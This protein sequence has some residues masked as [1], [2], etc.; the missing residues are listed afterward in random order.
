MIVNKVRQRVME[1]CK[2]KENLLTSAFFE[3]HLCVVARYG[4]LLAEAMNADSEMVEV[5]SYLHDLSAV[6]DFTTL[7]KHARE[8]SIQ[9]EA[10]LT[11]Y[12]YPG[13]KI[14]TIKNA[15]GLHAQPLKLGAGSPEAICLSNADAIAQIVNPSYWLF[16]AFRI[17]SMNYENGRQ[18]YLNKIKL[19]W[20]MLIP[21]ARKV[22]EQK[23]LAVAK[24]LEQ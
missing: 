16:F 23:Y 14:L 20:Q 7:A 12:E 19:N 5:A 22:A 17:M 2:A 13:D 4:I 11:E 1:T 21:E 8:S 6:R 24:C 9:A 10:L 15:I 18:W 3:E